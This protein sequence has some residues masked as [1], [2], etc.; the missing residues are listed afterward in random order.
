MFDFALI[1]HIAS[2]EIKLA[3]S[4]IH[5]SLL[6]ISVLGLCYKYLKGDDLASTE[7][8]FVTIL[9]M[10]ALSAVTVSIFSTNEKNL[11][12]KSNYSL[13]YIHLISH[14]K[15]SLITGILLSSLFVSLIFIS[16]IITAAMVFSFNI[17][18]FYIFI[19]SF[20][21]FSLF[22]KMTLLTWNC[23]LI[24]KKN[25]VYDKANPILIFFKNLAIGITTALSGSCL[26]FIFFLGPIFIMLNPKYSAFALF[27]LPFIF[28]IGLVY[29]S[30][31]FSKVWRDERL[32]YWNTKRDLITFGVRLVLVGC[33][34]LSLDLIL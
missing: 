17:T 23:H 10:L 24:R 13:K 22:L 4:R 2:H 33:I 29:S 6:S 34:V 32:S 28:S 19:P 11:S 21:I 20:I 7:F 12:Q 26:F 1:K 9:A 30:I 3:L 27:V 15:I 18:R 8:S 14:K 5:Y 16:M 31:N 25:Y